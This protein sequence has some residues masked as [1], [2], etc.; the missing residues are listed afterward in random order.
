[1]ATAVFLH[2]HPDDEAIATGGTM[3]LAAEAGHR[4][5]LVFATR[6]ECG[7]PVEGVLE[8]GEQLGDRRERESER[9]GKILGAQR[10]AFLGYRDSGMMGEPTNDDPTCFWA[11]D[12]DE[13]A[14]RLASIL[15]EEEADLITIYDDHGGYGHPDHIQVHRVGRAAAARAGVSQVF[16][17]TMNRD[18]IRRAIGAAIEAGAA[19]DDLRERHATL[20]DDH[21]PFGTPERELTHALDVRAMLDRKREAME[22]HASQIG[23]DSFFIAM[24][25]ERFAD[26]FGTEWYIA[27]GAV[28][29]GPPF[30]ADLF[31]D[32]P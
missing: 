21:E 8:D 1:M 2:A 9:A 6:G 16:E 26:A 20:D 11:A 4:V 31:A 19:D 28:R 22:A 30:A 12:E 29:V 32:F 7:E 27:H 10:V 3:A 14:G 5:I 18:H 17:S 25:D 15:R 24:D 13:A 23:P